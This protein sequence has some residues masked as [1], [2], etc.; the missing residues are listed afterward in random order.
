MS[1]FPDKMLPR[2]SWNVKKL[3]RVKGGYKRS[4]DR[5]YSI[6]SWKRKVLELGVE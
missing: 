6:I 1:R 2:M 4:G 5:L 3:C